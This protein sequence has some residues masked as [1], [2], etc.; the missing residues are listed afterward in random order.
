MTAVAIINRDLILQR[1]ANGD[2]LDVIASDLGISDAAISRQLSGDPDYMQARLDGVERRLRLSK[3]AVDQIADMGLDA[4]GNVVGLP[5]EVVNLA[6]VREIRLKADQWFAER[7]F[8]ERWGQ[9]TQVTV[10]KGSDLG[11]RL[12]RAR[13]RT[14]QGERVGVSL[15]VLDGDAKHT[16]TSKDIDNQ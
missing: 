1:V 3:R 16:D 8:P 9:H 10:N 7:E 14:V 11:D 4:E 13:E 2:Y 6:R 12:R 5:K 15:G